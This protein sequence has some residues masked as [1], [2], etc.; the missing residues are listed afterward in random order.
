M[1]AETS[2]TND[3]TSNSIC[4]VERIVKFQSNLFMICL[5]STYKTLNIYSVIVYY[6]TLFCVICLKSL[7]FFIKSLQQ[8]TIPL[9]H[10]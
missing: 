6:I 2:E 9:K 10:L 8:I 5:N 7:L 4:G 3:A 1:K